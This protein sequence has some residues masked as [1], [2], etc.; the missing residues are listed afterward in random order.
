MKNPTKNVGQAGLWSAVFD[1]DLCTGCAAC[2]NLCPSIGNYQDN[3]FILHECDRIDG[4]CHLYC[5]RTPTDLEELR[6][7]LFDSEDLGLELGPMKSFYVTRA[8]DVQVRDAA[9][10]GGT[11]SALISLAF[12]KGLVDAS[13]LAGQRSDFLPES[14][15][16][17]DPKE[18]PGKAGSKFVV[19]PTVGMFNR[20]C[21]GDAERIGVVATPCQCLALAKMRAYA[22]ETD[23]PCVEK[24]KLVIGLFCGWA[25][26]WRGFKALLAEKV[27][28]AEIIGVDIPPS[29]HQC[30][31]VYTNKGTVEVPIKDVQECVRPSCKYCPDMTAEFAD[32][33]VGSA[34]SPEGWAVD[35]GWN[36]VI[37]R[38][39]V[40]EEL[41]NLARE[42]GVLE[43]KTVP[44]GNL[45]KLKA[46][47][48]NKKRASHKILT[49]KTCG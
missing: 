22:E 1:Q 16:V 13:V 8:A 33:S 41:L 23:K 21:R 42:E 3:T 36:Q 15:T 31:E 17:R 11:V 14:V 29:S 39:V 35:R 9:Q 43:F 48:M 10:H 44:D 25:L 46:A 12:R 4:R 26:S 30:M 24:L 34:R 20:A 38:T 5:P 28:D 47:S 7:L 45:D 6:N 2:V 32:I 37:V 18:V 49:E 19:S 40:G 27:R